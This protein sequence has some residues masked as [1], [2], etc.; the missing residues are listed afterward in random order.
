M[1]QAYKWQAHTGPASVGQVHAGMDSCPGGPFA[2]AGVLCEKEHASKTAM[3]YLTYSIF[4]ELRSSLFRRSP[5]GDLSNFDKTFTKSVKNDNI[6]TNNDNIYIY[7]HTR[8]IHIAY[9]E[10]IFPYRK[11]A[12]L[13]PSRKVGK[14]KACLPE[15]IPSLGH[16]QLC[17]KGG[18]AMVCQGNNKSRLR[19]IERERYSTLP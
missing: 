3:S 13:P 11:P 12:P 17:T 6:L 8:M 10:F 1:S 7:I 15:W 9:T 19:Y 18:R 5:H 4:T 16:P 2:M 14:Y